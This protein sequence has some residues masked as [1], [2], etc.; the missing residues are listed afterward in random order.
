MCMCTFVGLMDKKNHSRKNHPSISDSAI[1]LDWIS[2]VSAFSTFQSVY[3]ALRI[4]TCQC[5]TILSVMRCEYCVYEFRPWQAKTQNCCGAE[6][7]RHGRYGRHGK[8]WFWIA[9]SNRKTIES[10]NEMYK[11]LS[12]WCILEVF[13]VLKSDARMFLFLLLLS[14]DATFE[15]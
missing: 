8:W 6:W 15:Q 10:N 13:D 11:N 12:V 5:V 7:H 14:S 4:F 9:D 2:H 1:S 3:L